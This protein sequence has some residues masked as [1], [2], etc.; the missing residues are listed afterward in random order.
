ML[1]SDRGGRHTGTA[2]KQ[3]AFRMGLCPCWGLLSPQLSGLGLC[4]CSISCFIAPPTR[5]LQSPA[6]GS[7]KPCLVPV[8]SLRQFSADW[9]GWCPP[10]ADQEGSD[11]SSDLGHQH[12]WIQSKPGGGWALLVTVSPFPARFREC[13]SRYCIASYEIHR[14]K[15]IPGVQV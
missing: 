12:S 6:G 4:C 10:A 1:V 15:S 5:L 8:L 14:L 9:R 7:V 3:E 11:W 13:S 2:D